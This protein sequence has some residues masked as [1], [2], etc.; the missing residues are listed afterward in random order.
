MGKPVGTLRPNN[1]S[2]TN[3]PP[4]ETPIRLPLRLLRAAQRVLAETNAGIQRHSTYKEEAH[5]QDDWLGDETQAIGAVN[6][7]AVKKGT[8]CC[9]D[10]AASYWNLTISNCTKRKNTMIEERSCT[11]AVGINNHKVYIPQ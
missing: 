6:M 10:T 3:T 11:F 7:I 1:A 9:V 8:D 2:T 5:Q 4:T